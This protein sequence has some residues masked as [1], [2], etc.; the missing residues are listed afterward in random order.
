MCRLSAELFDSG[1]PSV[2]SVSAASFAAGP[3]APEAISA[4]FGPSLAANAQTAGELPLPTQL[5]G[6]SVR[7]RDSLSV[8]RLAS[9]FFVSPRQ[10]NYQIPSGT[11]GGQAIV[12]VTSGSAVL[13]AGV[14]VI[15]NVAPGLFSANA[16][17]QSVAAAVVLRIKAD[18]AQIFEPVA[19]FD[20]GLNRF[21]AA[22]IDLGPASDQVFLALFGTG[23]RFRSAL[24]AVKAAIGGTD[25]EVLFADAAPGFVGLDQINVRLPRSL[26]GRGEIDVALSV[27]GRAANKV[28]VSVR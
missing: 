23:F 24:S 28:R 12:T 5:A 4:A 20:A 26:A 21:V 1:A 9:L 10:I 18:G 7:V 25:S 27:D 22:P 19:Q 17:G 8:E 3:L 2:A 16:D 15:A 6:V 14:A 13:A 11:A